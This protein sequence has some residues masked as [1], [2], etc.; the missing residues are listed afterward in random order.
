MAG[1]IIDSKQYDAWGNIEIGSATGGYA[2]TGREWDPETGLYYYRARYYDPKAGRF[3][4]ED[5]AGDGTNVYAYVGNNPANSID[6]TGHVAVTQKPGFWVG[7]IPI[8]GSVMMARH[9]FDCGNWGWGLFD[10]GMAIS[11]VFL[12]KAAATAVGKGAIWKLG[13]HSWPATRKWLVNIGWVEA[14]EE[15]HHWLLQQNQ[16]IG[17]NVPNVIKNQPYN[18]MSLTKAEHTAVH[19]MTGLE[20]LWYGT[21]TAAKAAALS[22]GGRVANE[23]AGPCGCE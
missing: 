14:G 18:I 17:R 20:R 3:I 12:V 19:Q 5:S 10:T 16:G 15:G 4:S 13:G 22:A 6:P 11:D 7:M 1:A 21:P 23:A 8:Y 2:F 9:D